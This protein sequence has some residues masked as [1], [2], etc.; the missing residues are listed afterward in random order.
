MKDILIHVCIF[1]ED[2]DKINI[3]LTSCSINKIKTKIY[4]NNKIHIKKILNHI[5]YNRFTNIITDNVYNFPLNIKKLEFYNNF[6]KDILSKSIIPNSITR[7]KFNRLFTSLIL[8]NC[9]PDSVTDL[10]FEKFTLDLQI[11]SI[12]KSVIS[13]KFGEFF[14]RYS[15]EDDIYDYTKIIPNSV[16]YLTLGNF[17]DLEAIVPGFIPNSVTHLIFAENFESNIIPGF[18]PNSVTHLTF[19]RYFNNDITDCI[20]N[21]VTHLTFG[22]CFNKNIKGC[23]PNSVT[24]L[25]FGDLF[26]KPICEYEGDTSF[27]RKMFGFSYK[28][29]IELYIPNSVTNLTFG[30]WFYQSIIIPQSVINLT[31]PSDKIN[32]CKKYI[33]N[34]VKCIE[35]I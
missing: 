11:N 1:L 10:I 24:H 25:I 8:P 3:L 20:P 27:F 22:Y 4:F 16:K 19:G 28:K 23:I 14:G 29:V 6:D 13:L 9:I 30:K 17:F 21:S 31:L 5:C 33:E 26:N 35:W 7:L 15:Y 2:I 18:I 32:Y 12:P 34:S